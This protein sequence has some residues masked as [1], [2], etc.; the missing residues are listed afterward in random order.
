[1]TQTNQPNPFAV[2][3]QKLSTALAAAGFEA[4][5]FNPGQ[6]L[7]YLTGLNFHLSERPVVVLFRPAQTP[8][9]VLPELEAAKVKDLP[10]PLQ[11]F[12]Y[13]ED[14]ATWAEVF[15]Q[16]ID[17]A[18][19]NG[20]TVG[21]EP[22]GL[23]FL[24][25]K[26]LEGAAPKARFQSAEESLASLRMYKDEGEISAMSKAAQ[27]AQEALLATL[28]M[29]RAG[30]TERQI[31][32]ELTVQLLR[33]GSSPEMPFSPI[34]SGGPNSANP[35]ATPSDR[36]L[37]EGDMLVIDWGASYNGYFSDITRTFA[38]GR[39]EPEFEKIYQLVLEAN[40]MGRGAC[41]PKN[42]AGDVDRAAR[43]VIE[44]GGYGPYFRHRTGHGLGMDVHEEPYM[45]AGNPM[46]L[47]PGMTFTVEPGIYLLGR[48]GVR[49]EDDMLITSIGGESLTDLPRE[50]QV[51]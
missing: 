40:E 49:I 38:I 2:R 32:S 1:M 36:V 47:A 3:Q 11:S 48:G 43:K 34:V 50:L 28:P 45:R 46:P 19:V 5:A 12:T 41:I 44:E 6:S 22:R 9:I 7:I 4:A 8:V 25:L 13:G 16:A 21:V 15:H 42:L 33:S 39:I 26:L 20:K 27:I 10:Y 14:P 23:R 30:V 35:H 31:A 24:E 17:A 29:V 37:Q 51:L 18:R